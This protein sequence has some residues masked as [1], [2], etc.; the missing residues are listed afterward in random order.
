MNFNIYIDDETGERLN[1]AAHKTGQSRN[2][3][4]RR[5]LDDWLNRRG[6][7][8]WPDEVAGFNGLASMPRFEDTRDKLK[9]PASDPLA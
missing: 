1:Q 3:L 8:Q 7:S 6:A 2:A 5:A 9:P 4:I